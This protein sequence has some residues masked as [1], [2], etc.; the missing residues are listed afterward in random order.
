[1]SDREEVLLEPAYV[2]HRR[3]YR[4]TSLIVEC[5]TSEHGRQTLV[6][7]GARRS[8]SRQRALLQPFRGL[9]VSWVR[10]GEMGRLTQVEADARVYD[11]AGE[12]LLAG[13][14]SNELLLRLLP[15]GDHNAAVLSCYSSCLARLAD[16]RSASRALRVFERDLLEMLGFGIDL[17]RDFRTG[18][19]IEPGR[20]YIF[21]HEGGLTA[22]GAN[23]TM[24]RY[25]GRH[26]IALRT[27]ELKDS[28]S[29][30]SARRLLGG[31]LSAHLGDRPLKTSGVLREI[32]ELGCNGR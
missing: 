18:E 32:V 10:R 9:R 11:L 22:S 15:R 2:L 6:A 26:L 28:E 5:L 31:I 13:F 29:L 30:R 20:D 24:K 23:P 7:Q 4:N 19:P 16:A 17:E 12:N 3:P 27:G 8:E 25:S 1:M 21:E 14:Y